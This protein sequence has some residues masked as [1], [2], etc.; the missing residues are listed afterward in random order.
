MVPA[1]SFVILED[2]KALDGNKEVASN[3]VA[4]WIEL[5]SHTCAGDSTG[6]PTPRLQFPT[7]WF[8][9]S[10]RGTFSP[11]VVPPTVPDPSENPDSDISQP[12]IPLA[13]PGTT[14]IS[15]V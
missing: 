11:F 8:P 1:F 14:D 9:A 6:G 13:D 10:P 15:R 2:K 12:S 7:F 5:C 4:T 3:Q